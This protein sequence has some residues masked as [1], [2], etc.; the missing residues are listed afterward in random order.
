MLPLRA[1]FPAVASLC[2]ATAWSQVAGDTFPPPPKE[3]AV[4]IAE[5]A[6]FLDVSFPSAHRTEWP[7]NNVVRARL[8]R[9]AGVEEPMPIVILLHGLGVADHFLEERIAKRLNDRGIAALLVTLP[10]HI[11]R[12]PPG[13]RSG[14]LALR[15]DVDAFEEMVR[16]SVSDLRRAVD[17]AESQRFVDADRIGVLGV[18]LGAII[19]SL[20]MAAEP[21]LRFGVFL[22]GGG[23]VAH[24]LWNSSLTISVREVLR[25]NGWT[26]ERLRARLK[27][28]EP[29]SY[30]NEE[31]GERV[32][33]VGALF[34]TVVP[35]TDTDKLHRALGSPP[36][37]WL[38]TGH[39]GAVFV[40]RR[41]LRVVADF[42]A[43]RFA[44]E[45]YS[46]PT[47][48]DAP[49]IRIGLML[50]Q[51]SGLQVAAG[52][53]LWRSNSRGDFYA[54][55]FLTTRGPVLFAGWKGPL[56][57]SVGAVAHPKRTVPG[58]VW[59]FVL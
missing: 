2:V 30:A 4:Q 43:A 44:G 15:P 46:P 52:L 57:F 16:Q 58:V 23:D 9:P 47:S 31:I 36:M 19:A 37:L 25:R 35:A 18:S 29:L 1:L 38:E 28:V 14:A 10:Y 51:E 33:L 26:E 32:L 27:A 8:I 5:K 12:S 3:F 39:Y 53:D 11:E 59:H 56:G 13:Y 21:R 49:T 48:I 7:E 50:D 24:I 42:F 54:S 6:G 45:T 55:G 41:L 34:D 20:G 17:W 22:L 40:E